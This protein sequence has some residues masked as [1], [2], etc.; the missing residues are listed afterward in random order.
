VNPN[1]PRPE[2][3]V[4]LGA[5]WFVLSGLCDEI[6]RRN[7]GVIR[8]VRAQDSKRQRRVPIPAQGI[9]LGF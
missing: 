7:L 8:P 2:P 1:S 3:K 5:L 4:F 6:G 9:A